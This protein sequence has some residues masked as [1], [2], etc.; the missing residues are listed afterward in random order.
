ML[1]FHMFACTVY[2]EL[3]G[4]PR[5]AR[6]ACPPWRACPERIQRGESRSATYGWQN[7]S[8]SNPFRMSTCKSVSKQTTLSIFRMNTYGKH[9]GWGAV[10]VN[11]RTPIGILE[12]A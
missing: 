3:R 5:S 2:P 9:R 11:H 12:G 6:T 7:H 8:S 4:E 10:I 1:S